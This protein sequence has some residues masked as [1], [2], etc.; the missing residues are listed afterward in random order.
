MP[1]WYPFQIPDCS[2]TVTEDF[3]T[4]LDLSST[5]STGLISENLDEASEIVDDE[6]SG[7]EIFVK[8]WK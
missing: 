3:Y 5:D 7:N 6:D 1:F 8:K 4:S 2:I